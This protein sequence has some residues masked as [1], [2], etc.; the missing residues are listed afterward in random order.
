MTEPSIP[1]QRR[2]EAA[3]MSLRGR[4]KSP[5]SFGFVEALL[6]DVVLPAWPAGL[7]QRPSSVRGHRLALSAL[8]SD[9][10]RLDARGQ[11]GK[12]GVADKDF[13][14]LGFSRD[15]FTRTKDALLDAGLLEHVGGW[16][17]FT[18]GFEGAIAPGLVRGAAVSCFGLTETARARAEAA[19]LLTADLKAWSEHWEH[20]K[21]P[22]PTAAPALIELK[23][24]RKTV[25]GRKTD[26]PTMSIDKRDVR[27]QAIVAELAEHNEYMLGKD[28]EGVPFA[29]LKRIFN[30]GN[31]AGFAWQWGGRFT[32]L[33]GGGYEV[34]PKA[35]RL[36][37]M[38]LGGQRVAE[39]DMQASHLTILRALAGAEEDGTPDPYAVA[40]LDRE[41]VKRWVTQ[42][43]GRGDAEATV[44]SAEARRYYA[45]VAPGRPLSKDLPIVDVR[46]AVLSRH[47]VLGHLGEARL[48]V[49]AL[50]FHESEIVAL[51]MRTLRQQ[52]V[53]SL[54]VHDCLI[55]PASA[56]AAA[57][58][59]L[60]R[61]FEH[62]M[63]SVLGTPP[64]VHLSTKVLNGRAASP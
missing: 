29:G 50:N 32:S 31:V 39:V 45:T 26:A 2:D 36:A 49:H 18:A 15:I 54:P 19:G 62:H 7:Q 53:P 56:V 40:G 6:Q 47:P 23:G 60:Q 24:S 34:E 22:R 37:V 13:V 43:I 64:V 8:M 42:A 16:R 63:T 5:A 61:N 1:W 46:A 27:A 57:E 9:L 17:W 51:A 30:N 55:V 20:V 21:P 58:D 59:A 4:C 25:N 3:F 12:H 14:G 28:V 35:D 44:W 10:L 52:D 38:R 41:L 48:S 33:P 11:A